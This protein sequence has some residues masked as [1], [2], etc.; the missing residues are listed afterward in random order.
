MERL[1]GK[2]GLPKLPDYALGLILAEQLSGP[3][4]A[5]ADHLR[6]SFTA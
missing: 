1:D 4:R 6:A 5:A 2:G 3:A